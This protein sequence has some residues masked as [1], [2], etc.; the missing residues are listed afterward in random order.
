MSRWEEKQKEVLA[1]GYT[2]RF[3]RKFRCGLRWVL[4]ALVLCGCV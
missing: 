3:W 4:F 1:L 2:E